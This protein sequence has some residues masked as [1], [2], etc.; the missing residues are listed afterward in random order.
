MRLIERSRI[1]RPAAVV[2]P[3]VIRP[4]HFKEWSSKIDSMDVTGEF[5]VGQPFTTHY[6]W[7]G[8]PL[9]CASVA[10]EI[11]PGRVLELKHSALMGPGIKPGMEVRERITLDDSW[12][13]R[14]SVTKTITISNH[15]VAWPW[16]L[17]IW[18]INRFGHRVE[19]DPLKA[20]VEGGT[21]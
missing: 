16:L 6:L 5:R 2:W 21:R 7:N 13:G 14:T 20:L 3:Y 8:K 18:F 19:P 12:G 9:Q 17:L 11:E 15:D 1:D 10:T 4:E